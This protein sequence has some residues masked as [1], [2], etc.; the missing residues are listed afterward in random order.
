VTAIIDIETLISEVEA[1]CHKTGVSVT[2]FC[3]DSTGNPSL[4]TQLRRGTDPRVSTVNR[5]AKAL[6]G[7]A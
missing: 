6:A 5:L 4:L 1:H 7:A 2:E 3:R